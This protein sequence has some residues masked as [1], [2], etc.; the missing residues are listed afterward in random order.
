MADEKEKN[1]KVMVSRTPGGGRGVGHSQQPD[2][3]RTT[4][5]APITS[6][7][8]CLQTAPA[9]EY[10]R[11]N[12]AAEPPTHGAQDPVRGVPPQPSPTCACKTKQGKA[13]MSS[14]KAKAGRVRDAARAGGHA[15]RQNTCRGAAETPWAHKPRPV[16]CHRCCRPSAKAG[17]DTATCE[18]RTLFALSCRGPR[19]RKEA[20]GYLGTTSR[21]VPQ[22]RTGLLKP[23]AKA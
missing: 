22:S 21:A 2:H 20:W 8:T 12:P 3:S 1:G 17:E 6:T 5:I 19:V 4:P 23:R 15:R 9:R 7:C 13:R 16:G 11:R 10:S 14:A 18:H